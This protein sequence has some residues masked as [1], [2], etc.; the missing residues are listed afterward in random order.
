MPLTAKLGT[1]DSRPG[2]I[3]PGL[4]SA[5]FVASLTTATPA[6]LV[7]EVAFANNPIDLAGYRNT[8]LYGQPVSYWRMDNAASLIDQAGSGNTMTLSNSPS[9]VS[10]LMSGDSN[11]ALQFNGTNQAGVVADAASLDFS[12]AMSVEKI[13]SLP[14]LP[15]STK[16]I[17]GK[18]DSFW[19]E[20]TAA[21]KLQ[22][23][24]RTGTTTATVV[25]VATLSTTTTYHVAGVYDGTALLLYINGVLDNSQAYSAGIGTTAN[26][27]VVG[28]KDDST[29]SPTYRDV[30]T[31]ATGSLGSTIGITTPA[32]T[33]A[34]DYLIGM[35]A[36]GASNTMTTPPED[37]TLLGQTSTGMFM[38]VYGKVA[39]AADA[40]GGASYSWEFGTAQSAFRGA[41]V[42][43]ANAAGVGATANNGTASATSVSTT[44]TP[45]HN[46]ATVLSL[47][48]HNSS[49]QSWTLTP[50]TQ[51]FEQQN[52]SVTAETTAVATSSL[53][54]EQGTTAGATTKGVFAVELYGPI[55]PV[56][57]TSQISDEV[58]L[59]DRALSASDVASH[60]AAM[61]VA[62]TTL[63][64]TDIS[65]D[66]RACTIAR[67]RQYELG[68]MEAGTAS[69]VVKD[70][71]RAYDPANTLS[72]NA[73]NVLPLRQIRIRALFNSTYYPL[74][75]GFVER[76]ESKW[77]TDYVQQ[78]AE[79]DIAGVDGFEPL[80]LAAPTG[81]IPAGLSG[82]S[83]GSILSKANW[84]PDNRNIDAGA[85][86]IAAIALSGSTGVLN[87]LQ[88]IAAGEN[89]IFFV[90]ASGNAVFHD[91]NH[92]TTNTTSTTSQATFSDVPE[93][94]LPYTA[95]DPSFDKDH[96]VNDWHVTD[97]D[98]TDHQAFDDTS[99]RKYFRRTQSM[100]SYLSAADAAAM[101]AY[102]LA[103]TKDPGYRFDS[104]EITPN[105]TLEVW[106]Q[107][108]NREISDRITVHRQPVGTTPGSQIAKD[109]WI[110]RVE[111]NITYGQPW[112]VRWQLSP[113]T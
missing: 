39:T 72:P 28:R 47:F 36:A 61:S 58:S 21:G 51:Q 108:L 23:S 59:W 43:M 2:N 52:T 29:A 16:W 103:H 50:G 17:A 37:W 25:S 41:I 67:G 22:F 99:I 102:L 105:T 101:V 3:I 26:P 96:I 44:I 97:S 42:A 4:G 63:T 85:F 79:V 45:L 110:E 13:V 15:A 104:I 10:S 35:V 60:R 53:Q 88:D 100:T 86:P 46:N 83:I 84:P 92:R 18:A 80:N 64:W 38:F 75:R 14:S 76:W 34:G 95:L 56:S 30:R 65:S 40:A 94:V 55:G 12:T 112:R 20:V 89:G 32:A 81:T 87:Y 69:L 98:G 6:Q 31:A 106:T 111:W 33:V 77:S 19:L 8:N 74:F 11:Q 93:G 113:A 90:D 27:F 1:P 78:Y 5:R 54:T 107:A 9:L 109:C 71:L 57:Y 7:V 73:P 70:T 91:K 24:V 68:Q 62:P 48:T 49:A 82:Q 66:V